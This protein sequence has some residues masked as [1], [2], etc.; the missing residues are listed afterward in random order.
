V[1]RRITAGRKVARSLKAQE[2]HVRED[3]AKLHTA[4]V[5][6]LLLRFCL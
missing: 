3:A 5:R 2:A 1:L 4:H 6:G